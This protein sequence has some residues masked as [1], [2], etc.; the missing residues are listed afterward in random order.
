MIDEHICDTPG[1]VF[2]ATWTLRVHIG[3]SET[4]ALTPTAAPLQM[5]TWTTQF[6][7]SAAVM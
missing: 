7:V 5:Q 1:R 2:H 3:L 4:G 6:T